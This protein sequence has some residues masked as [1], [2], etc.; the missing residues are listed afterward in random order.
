MFDGLFSSIGL[1]E[2]IAPCAYRYFVAGRRGGR[3]EGVKI[4]SYGE[5]EVVFSVRCGKLIV[6]GRNLSVKKYTEN[7]AELSGEII[8]VELK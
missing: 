5:N 8:G 3:F 7:E 6:N 4:E 1:S 2:E